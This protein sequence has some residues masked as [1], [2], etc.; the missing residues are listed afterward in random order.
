MCRCGIGQQRGREGGR[1]GKE[2]IFW[3]IIHFHVC[4]VQMVQ[5]QLLAVQLQVYENWC[6]KLENWSYNVFMCVYVCIDRLV[7]QYYDYYTR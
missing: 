4:L 7:K 2:Y 3:E 6:I 5:R 1:D